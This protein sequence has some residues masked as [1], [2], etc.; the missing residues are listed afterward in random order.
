MYISPRESNLKVVVHSPL[1]SNRERIMPLTCT[2]ALFANVGFIHSILPKAIFNFN[3][4]DDE[5]KELDQ[6]TPPSQCIPN[7]WC[8]AVD[9]C[10]MDGC[11]RCGAA[12]DGEAEAPSAAERAAVAFQNDVVGVG[13]GVGGK[14]NS[15]GCTK[16]CGKCVLK[17]YGKITY[18]AN[19]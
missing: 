13:V 12:D 7:K 15:C 5:M 9:E 1:Q 19:P 10:T 11:K 16:C 3:L 14:C 18:C 17:T 8:K 2:L 6:Y 4:T